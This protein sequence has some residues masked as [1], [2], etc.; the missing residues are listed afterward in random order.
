MSIRNNC[1]LFFWFKN[2][3][4]VALCSGRGIQDEQQL[5]K[6]K[7]GAE[8][9]QELGCLVSK[10]VSGEKKNCFQK[11]KKYNL[12]SPVIFFYQKLIHQFLE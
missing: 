9:T 2:Y 4:I 7:I 6:F 3:I 1:N 10:V 11:R 12:S 8:L 5:S